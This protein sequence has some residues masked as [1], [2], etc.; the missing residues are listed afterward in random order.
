MNIEEELFQKSILNPQKLYAQ[1]FQQVAY[2]FH[3]IKKFPTLP[4]VAE[5]TIALK[6]KVTGHVLDTETNE[7]YLP[8]LA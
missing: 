7:E 8:F 3:G 4:F 6:G 1:G 2:G 5:I